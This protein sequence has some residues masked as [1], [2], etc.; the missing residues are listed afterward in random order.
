MKCF[1]SHVLEK[2]VT[3]QFVKEDITF[4]KYDYF[5]SMPDNYFRKINFVFFCKTELYGYSV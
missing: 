1:I 2:Q 5:F 4:L 3:V